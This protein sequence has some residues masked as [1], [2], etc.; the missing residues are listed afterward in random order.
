MIVN[1]TRGGLPGTRFAANVSNAMVEKQQFGLNGLGYTADDAARAVT[2]EEKGAAADFYN[3]SFSAAQLVNTVRIAGSGSEQALYT[4]GL[5]MPWLKSLL[6]S[7]TW[8]SPQ[9][10]LILQQIA[11]IESRMAQ[12]QTRVIVDGQLMHAAALQVLAENMPQVMAEIE[13][14]KQDLLAQI[15]A[16]GDINVYNKFVADAAA[17]DSAAKATAAATDAIVKAGGTY[18]P[19]GVVL[20][21]IFDPAVV[22]AAAA[23]QQK[24]LAVQAA[25]SK[26]PT[27]TNPVSNAGNI[28]SGQLGTGSGAGRIAGGT[29]STTAGGSSLQ[30]KLQ[31]VIKSTGMSG[32][33]LALIGAGLVGMYLVMNRGKR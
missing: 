24:R 25:A 31:E 20:P 7:Q 4:A 16:F 32:T 6:V 12:W 19:P 22:A 21:R 10:Q 5:F 13:R 26:L 29:V 9:Q 11:G 14:N 1:T 17:Y 23:A 2:P 28:N 3:A 27:I 18:S 33:T 30:D 8:N 15:R